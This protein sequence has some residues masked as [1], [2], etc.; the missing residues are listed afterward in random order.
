MTNFRGHGLRELYLLKAGLFRNSSENCDSRRLNT[1]YGANGLRAT[2][3]RVSSSSLR[4]RTRRRLTD[5]DGFAAT[6]RANS[7]LSSARAVNRS[8]DVVSSAASSLDVFAIDPP[9]L[10]VQF[11]TRL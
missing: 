8:S 4:L 3:L 9:L 11:T 6:M 2:F 1:S 5:V 7:S 10:A